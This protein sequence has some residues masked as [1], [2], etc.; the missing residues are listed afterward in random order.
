MTVT[1][2]GQGELRAGPQVV[3][4]AGAICSWGLEGTASEITVWRN[5][6]NAWAKILGSVQ[7]VREGVDEV[8]PCYFPWQLSGRPLRCWVATVDE[9]TRGSIE[10]PRILGGIH[11][12]PALH[13]V[14][15]GT[16]SQDLD[17]R[18]AAHGRREYANGGCSVLAVGPPSPHL[19]T[20]RPPA[21]SDIV[22]SRTDLVA[23][24]TLSESAALVQATQNRT[25]SERGPIPSHPRH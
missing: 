15:F 19:G 3:A 11:P 14:G 18:Y 6:Q 13:K 1:G 16:E 8:V 23:S 4:A 17:G 22:R 7:V 24:P 12:V 20:P 2:S 5:G 21:E 10:A 9:G 25:L